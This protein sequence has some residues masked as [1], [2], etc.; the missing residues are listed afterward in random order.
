M[1]K[2]PAKKVSGKS[3]TK[4]SR[5]PIKSSAKPPTSAKKAAMR[6]KRDKPGNTPSTRRVRPDAVST[7]QEQAANNEKALKARDAQQAKRDLGD[8][9]MVDAHNEEES[10]TANENLADSDIDEEDAV[11]DVLGDSDDD[12]DDDGSDMD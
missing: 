11:D 3:G 2:K 1:S 8:D 7:P 10:D 12:M 9:G 6:P 5:A 4:A